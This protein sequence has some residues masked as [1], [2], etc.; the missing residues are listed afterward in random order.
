MLSGFYWGTVWGITLPKNI[1]VNSPD[2]TLTTDAS[3]K[4]WGAVLEENRTGGLWSMEELGASG[5]WN[6]KL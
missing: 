5:A 6:N 2:I 4:G 3:T 1:T